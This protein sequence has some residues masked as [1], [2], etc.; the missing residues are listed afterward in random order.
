MVFI[1]EQVNVDRLRHQIIE[2]F[3]DEFMERFKTTAKR[4]LFRDGFS[5]SQCVQLHQGNV[6]YREYKRMPRMR[7]VS[8]R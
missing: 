7:P 1:Q 3:C 8:L 6:T 5:R 2:K 4:E